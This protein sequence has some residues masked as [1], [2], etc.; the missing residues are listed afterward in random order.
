MSAPPATPAP[1][2]PR[3]A[4][5][6]PVLPDMPAMRCDEG[7]TEC[8]SEMFG[9]SE[10]EMVRVVVFANRYGVAPQD[11]PNMCPWYQRG[12]CAVHEARPIVCRV[13]GHVDDPQMAC[14]R[15]YN[16]NVDSQ[17]RARTHLAMSEASKGPATRFLAEVQST[18]QWKD[19]VY[20]DQW[21]H[22]QQA[23]LRE[24]LPPLPPRA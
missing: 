13:F 1:A 14:P 4:L 24:G 18:D 11:D 23:R 9:V 20:P 12:R 3:A 15:G 10:A 8:C 22:V 16:A 21:A 7:C 6:L 19:R 2:P 17:D 5:R